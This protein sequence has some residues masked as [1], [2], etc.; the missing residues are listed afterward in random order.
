M[1]GHSKWHNIQKRKGAVD[2]KR[3]KEFATIA[4]LIR[5]AVKEG[6]S[7]NPDFNPRL[8]LMM[9]KARAANMP[10]DKIKKAILRG[11]GKSES[12]AQVQ[13]VLYEGYGPEGVA[14]LVQAVTDNPTRTSAEM[15]FIFSRNGGALAGPNAA[16]FMFT[17]TE[18]GMGFE[19]AMPMQVSADA[20]AQLEAMVEAFETHDDVESVFHTAQLPEEEQ[21]E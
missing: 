2:T 16:Q 7:D 3:A 1:A 15:K 9:D 18:D 20:Q 4:K 21:G 12:G 14:I 6:G 13:E 10:N 8:R 11:S 17:K 19:P 5:I